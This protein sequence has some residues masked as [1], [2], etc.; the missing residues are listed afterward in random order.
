[1][2]E[3]NNNSRKDNQ[4]E[5]IQRKIDKKV[6]YNIAELLYEKDWSQK[7]FLD[8]LHF[9]GYG[10]SKSSLNRILNG[11]QY[12]PA[13]FVY[14]AAKVLN[15]SADFLLFGSNTASQA[16][17][18]LARKLSSYNKR[19]QQDIAELIDCLGNI[20]KN[21]PDDTNN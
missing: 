15:V 20:I 17:E 5:D 7:K 16:T 13:F 10:I 12:M 9:E 8:K 6:G 1:M 3:V 19:E 11:E 4:A 18:P 21:F 14:S 2:N